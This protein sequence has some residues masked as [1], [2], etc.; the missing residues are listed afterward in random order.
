MNRTIAATLAAAAV[1]LGATACTAEA[2]SDPKSS[3]ATK[4][5]SETP[6]RTDARDE[7][8]P[9]GK[10][11]N[12]NGVKVSVTPIERAVSS[13]T[14][15]PAGKP[16]VKLAVKVTNGTNKQL[17]ATA[18]QPVCT[19]KNGAKE[20]EGVFDD[21][22]KVGT[23]ASRVLLKGQSATLTHGCAVPKGVQDLQVS[24]TG[25]LSTVVW[26]GSVK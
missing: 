26:K 25:E 23:S 16:Y 3:A 10:E 1:A 18:A 12:H 2:S 5:P 15:A 21:A 7:V 17:D 22:H 6:S 13:D 9:F 11:T 24:I 4:L 19:L 14:A 20:A 8:L